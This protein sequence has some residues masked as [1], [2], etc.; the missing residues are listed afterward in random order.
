[1]ELT[2]RLYEY[3]QNEINV[4]R[5]KGLSIFAQR[6]I[7]PGAENI[8]VSSMLFEELIPSLQCEFDE[9]RLDLSPLFW[10][11]YNAIK[12]FKPSY[13]ARK[14]D[15]SLE[16]KAHKNLK[17]ALKLIDPRESELTEFIKT[18]ITDIKKYHTLSKKT[19]GRLGRMDLSRSSNKEVKQAFFDEVKWIRNHLGVDYLDLILERVKNLEMEV[20]IGVENRI[21]NNKSR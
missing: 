20:I 8:E 4:I 14:S 11:G 19:L 21:L 13:K 9:E 5:R 6:V 16:S 15:I 1:M 18:L 17:V 3:F 12:E 2:V 7:D 10:P